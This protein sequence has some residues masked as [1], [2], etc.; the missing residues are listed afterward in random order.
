M[1]DTVLGASNTN[2]VQ[3]NLIVKNIK[4]THKK[5]IFADLQIGGKK[6]DSLPSH[7]QEVRKNSYNA[8]K[9]IMYFNIKT[10]YMKLLY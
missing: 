3:K 9:L 5:T 8:A 2:L 7:L 1:P 6:S 10:K 4:N